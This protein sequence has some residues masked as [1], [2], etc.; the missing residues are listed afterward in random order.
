MTIVIVGGGI[1]GL[2]AAWQL[3]RS[4]VDPTSVTVLEASPRV[5]GKLA[6]AEV[7]GHLVDVGAAF[8]GA[9]A[10]LDRPSVA[11]VV[12]DFEG[13]VDGFTWQVRVAPFHGAET[14]HHG[15]QLYRIDITVAWGDPGHSRDLTLSTLRLGALP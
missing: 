15:M 5:G 11:E 9:V 13:R 14:A 4:G 6:R 12:P 7:A 1:A 8:D 3:V 2:T 10:G